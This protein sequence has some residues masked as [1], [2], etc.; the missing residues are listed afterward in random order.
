[1]R[2]EKITRAFIAQKPLVLYG[3][4]LAVVLYLLQWLR[5]R[6]LILD[7]AFEVYIGAIALVFAVL[8][9]W[10]GLK[11]TRPQKSA[12]P[13]PPFEPKPTEINDLSSREMEVLQL[14]ADGLSNKEIAE[15]LFV[16]LSTVKTHTNNM[17][18]K[19]AVKRRT[20]AVDKGRKMGIIR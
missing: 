11:L 9:L 12:L 10:L 14:M 15:R 7:H 5:V 19:M 16:S 3:L 6:L 13:V 17:F 18:D 20:Q 1:M 2:S 4:S 8:G